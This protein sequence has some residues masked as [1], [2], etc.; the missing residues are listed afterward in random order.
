MITIERLQGRDG[1]EK[2]LDL[3]DRLNADDP[4][5]IPPL[6]PWVRRRLAPSNP[7]L[8]EATFELYGAK[9]GD[10]LVGAIS[11]LRDP[12]WERHKN[13]KTSFFGWYMS[14]DDP[15]VAEALLSTAAERA[16]A[17]GME[18]LRG[19]RNLT[20]IE[21]VGVTVEGFTA[22]PPMLASHHPPYVQKLVEGQ[23]FAKHH[24]VLAYDVALVNEDG[25]P[26]TLPEKLREKADKV[27]LPGLV[28][29]Q[30]GRAHV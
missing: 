18:T 12:S 10:Q 9:R 25:T 13:E 28:V 23:G 4:A 8:K 20:R 27:D 17:W 2:L 19:P 29:R 7:F 26:R 11:A 15:A 14:E 30:I 6:R 1:V 24:D 22:P 21:E 16:H 3:Q 5:F